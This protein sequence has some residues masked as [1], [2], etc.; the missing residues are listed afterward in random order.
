M[1]RDSKAAFEKLQR[2]SQLCNESST[3]KEAL[4]KV[5]FE[6]PDEDL[7]NVME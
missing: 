6:F 7:S 4:E 5:R 2:M 3:Q 1:P